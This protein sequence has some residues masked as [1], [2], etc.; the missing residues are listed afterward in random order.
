[1]TDIGSGLG[2]PDIVRITAASAAVEWGRVRFADIPQFQRGARA[3]VDAALVLQGVADGLHLTFSRP[4]SG[5]EIEIAPGTM[6]DR[7]FA[8]TDALTVELIPAGRAA[9]LRL[10]GSYDQLAQAWRALMA[11]VTGRDLDCTGLFWEVYSDPSGPVTDLYA[12]L[13]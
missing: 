7:A 5:I 1:M 6:I 11:W 13:K 10:E 3:R 9:H 8:P 12:L 2:K 4:S